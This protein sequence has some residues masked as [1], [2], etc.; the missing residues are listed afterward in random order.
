MD[1]KYRVLCIDDDLMYCGL[2]RDILEPKG[3]EVRC[4]SEISTGFT[5]AATGW[6]DIILLDAMM[7]EQGGF[8]DGYDLLQR[9]R[10]EASGKDVPVIMISGLAGEEDRKHGMDMGASLYRAKHEMVPEK[11]LA[12]IHSLIGGK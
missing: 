2:Y 11:L 7:P 6:P 4:A 1:K 9:L 10:S 12:D 8:R 5:M 3:F